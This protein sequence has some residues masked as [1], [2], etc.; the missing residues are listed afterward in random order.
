MPIGLLDIMG[1]LVISAL[2]KI[3]QRFCKNEIQFVK[4]V[5]H[6]DA[7]KAINQKPELSMDIGSA[8]PPDSSRRRNDNL[9]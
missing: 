6:S 8:A 7:D 2:M 3:A 1:I 5:V 9:G 4:M